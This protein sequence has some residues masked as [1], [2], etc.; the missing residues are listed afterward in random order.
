MLEI[1]TLQTLFTSYDE[2]WYVDVIIDAPPR[3]L[4]IYLP[5]QTTP[6]K[7]IALNNRVNRVLVWDVNP[8]SSTPTNQIHTITFKVAE[9]GETTQIDILYVT[10]RVERVELR[11]GGGLNLT[12]FITQ[13]VKFDN[14]TFYRVFQLTRF[15]LINVP[16]N[17]AVFH[18]FWGSDEKDNKYYYVARQDRIL[19][20][21]GG[22]DTLV[23]TLAPFT[24]Y[25]P[26]LI[27][28]DVNVYNPVAQALGINTRIPSIVVD[29]VAR[30]YTQLPLMIARFIIKY[31]HG[32]V[33]DAWIEGGELKVKVAV[34]APPL[35][36]IAVGALSLTVLGTV[37]ILTVKDIMLE[38]VKVITAIEAL[39]S[40]ARI[41]AEQ[42][43]AIQSAIEYAKQQNLPPEQAQELV[44]TISQAY[45]TGDVVKAIQA[46]AEATK[47]IPL[48]EKLVYVG[49]GAGV[50]AIIALLLR[51]GR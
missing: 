13:L 10:S 28:F 7:S 46:Y 22:A 16:D 5:G 2:P 11:P 31:V 1:R 45:A 12:G 30:Y 41:K 15:S 44:K 20:Q 8:I 29:F 32:E 9:T 36:L 25:V 21:L 23:V 38:A 24:G 3:T 51:G 40:I 17:T 39:N 35:W 14:K 18:E 26:V 43:T 6:F 34:D 47:G 4:E 19:Q 48:S 49:A 50:A 37:V 27:T 42:T 33:L